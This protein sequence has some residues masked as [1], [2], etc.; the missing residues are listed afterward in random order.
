M[1]GSGGGT[2][3]S[4]GCITPPTQCHAKTGTC[5]AGAC[6]YQFIEGAIC[7][8]GNDCTQGDVCGGGVC[9]GTPKLCNQ[10]PP[11]VCT[12][13]STLKVFEAGSCQSGLC[14]YTQKAVQCSGNCVNGAC[15]TD[16]CASVVCNSPPT[17]CHK[18]VGT[19]SAG[20]C[21]YAFDDGKSCTDGNACS[22]NDTC[23]AGVCQGAPKACNTP[24]PNSCSDA[25]TAKIYDSIGVCASGGCSYPVS[26]VSCANGCASGKCTSLGWVKMTSNTTYDLL[27][28][29]GSSANSVW[30]VG[31][32]AAVYYDGI[33]WQVRTPAAATLV[34]VHGTTPS[35]VFA[36]E[37]DGQVHKFDGTNWSPKVKVPGLTGGCIFVDG[38]DSYW[39]GGR[40]NISGNNIVSALYRVVG[41]QVTLAGGTLTY[42]ASNS[43]RCQVWAAS[44]TDVW[45]STGK[46]LR[47]D[48]NTVSEV[49]A[50]SIGLWGIAP[51]PVFMAYNSMERWNGTGLQ[52]FPLGL[53]GMIH[54]LHGTAANRV[55]AALEKSNGDGAVLFFDSIGWTQEPIP[56]GTGNLFDTYAAPTGEVFAVGKAGT[57]LKGP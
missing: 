21:S 39:V 34:D 22:D 8:D 30:A 23:N 27:S 9:L 16:P 35:N 20:A 41:S 11:A 50:A 40:D 24:P 31:S 3:C 15:A 13:P 19:C 14:V 51:N 52:A 49:G 28:V 5:A 33:K 45:L 6:S 2:G 56:A 38:P 36:V 18:G 10:P 42:M 37:F 25:S 47:Y 53:S 46:T 57:I 48:G 29:W 32:Q 55:F 4:G 12:G 43:N 7:N 44:P 54:G 26:F 17:S 1:A